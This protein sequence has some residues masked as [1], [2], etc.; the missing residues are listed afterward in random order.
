MYSIEAGKEKKRTGIGKVVRNEDVI[1]DRNKGNRG[2]RSVYRGREGD[3][4]IKT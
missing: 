1:F 3:T 2:I 4:L